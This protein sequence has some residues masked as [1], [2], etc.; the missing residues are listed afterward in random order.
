MIMHTECASPNKFYLLF[1]KFILPLQ[2]GWTYGGTHM[3]V[4]FSPFEMHFPPWKH[5]HS[6]QGSQI[7]EEIIV[8]HEQLKNNQRYPTHAPKSTHSTITHSCIK[9]PSIVPEPRHIAYSCCWSITII[10]YETCW[11]L[12]KTQIFWWPS[13]RIGYPAM[14]IITFEWTI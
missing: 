13:N 12:N 4:R 3:Q 9:F 2:S 14:Q 10:W 6:T 11:L 7:S 1:L 8:S 5:G